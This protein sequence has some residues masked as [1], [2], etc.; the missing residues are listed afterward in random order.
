M[1]KLSQEEVQATFAPPM[2]DVT[3]TAEEIVDLWHLLTL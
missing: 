2:L 3:K 1:K